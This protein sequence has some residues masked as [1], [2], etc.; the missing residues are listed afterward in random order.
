ML[1]KLDKMEKNINLGDIVTFEG[2]VCLV[3]E[4]DGDFYL[5][6]LQ[7]EKEYETIMSYDY[8]SDI[9]ED[10]RV[11]FVISA[12]DVEISEKKESSSYVW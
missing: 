12:D 11:H 1:L 10:D 5:L 8:L 9:D 3:I 7:G 2:T 4:V 6:A